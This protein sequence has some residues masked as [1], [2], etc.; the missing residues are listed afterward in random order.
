LIFAS[1]IDRRVALTKNTTYT[2]MRKLLII[3]L[4]AGMT[5][6][7]AQSQKVVPGVIEIQLQPEMAEQVQQRRQ[8][9]QLNVTPGQ[10]QVGIRRFDEL[11][12]RYG[13]ASLERIFP[14]AG[15]HEEKHRRAG[16]HLWYRLQVN[17]SS[18]IREA[19]KA[20]GALEEISAVS[21][22]YPIKHIQ[23]VTPAEALPAE[24]VPAAV[25]NDPRFSQQWHYHN[26]GQSG[27]ADVDIN[28]PEA[29]DITTGSTDVI[30]AVVDGGI[31]YVHPDIAANM[32]SGIGRN[33]INQLQGV[34]P[35]DHGTHVGGTIAAV[36]NNGVGVAGIAGG[37]G[38][39]NGVRLMSCQIFD[40]N[41]GNGPSA[42]AII[43]GADNG[44][45]ICQ[46]SW[47]YEDE[48]VY[49]QSD[50][51]AIRYFIATAGSSKMKGGIV[52]FAAGNNNSNGRRYPAYFDFVV[53][54]AAVTNRGVKASYSN[55][56]SWVTISA[57]GSGILSTRPNESYGLS[58]GTSMACPH[59]SGVAALIISKYG[60]PNFT[61]D[62]VRLRLTGSA[63]SLTSYDPDYAPMMGAGLVD[64]QAALAPFAYITNIVISGCPEQPV[65][66][67][68]TVRLSAT[69]S[70]DNAFDKKVLWS[71]ANK[72][73]ATVNGEGVV[74]ASGLGT[75]TINAR[76]QTGPAIASCILDIRPINVEQVEFVYD[77]YALTPG[78]H[79]I[80]RAN[81]IPNNASNKTIT[82][83]SDDPSIVAVS[84]G[85]ATA[86]KTG[87]TFVVA[88]SSDGGHTD[89]CYFDVVKPVTGVSIH[90]PLTKIMK[91]NTT[92]LEAVI[93]PPDANNKRV[94]WQSENASVADIDIDAGVL[95]AKKGGS[96]TITV[97]TEDGNHTAIAQVEVSETAH[98][99][100]G[101]SPN[102]DG[103]NDYF[104]CTLDSRDIYTLTVFDRS[105]QV[106]YRSS[107]YQND[108]D[109]TANT[110]PHA[111][112]KVPVNTYFYTLSAKNDGQTTTGFVV[113][114]Y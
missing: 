37:S 27:I 86:V 54:V 29:W 80:L 21:A 70:P 98:A 64:A 79:A 72:S 32:W 10:L 58:N 56:G 71:S 101:F 68:S 8:A 106:H 62:S 81:V 2:S 7:Y 5:S 49:N 113:V 40:S 110:G 44:A 100:E 22:V 35:E 96:A 18:D 61:P 103:V 95:S 23:A 69:V 78:E 24:P 97:T 114:K 85:T 73:I 108:W 83:A 75:V 17:K 13:A 50:S 42:N 46:N 11:N 91:G 26:T 74:T 92:T 30:V 66:T 1:M 52:I 15:E 57:P 28:L 102:G 43:Y 93:E 99:P 19:V 51:V 36:S 34:T 104:V 4:L 88:T 111:G 33:F 107:D 67:G 109:G 60:H 76:A 48:G 38:S 6:G 41:D 45:V 55:Y 16:L 9:R 12:T 39:G 112:N 25:S 77:Y 94:F 105:G 47:G 87:N 14:D 82:F 3:G 89:T 20:Y 84:G 90:P 63:R 65:H 59:V 31:D 53:S